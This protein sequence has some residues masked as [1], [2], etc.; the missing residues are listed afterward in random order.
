MTASSG[1]APSGLQGRALAALALVT[2]ISMTG[3]GLIIPVVPFLSL[4]LGASPTEVTGAIGVYSIGQFIASPLWGKMSD[5]WGRR[6]VLLITLS[7]AAAL[8]LALPYAGS[9][10]MLGAIRFAAGLAAGNVATAFAVAA[11][12]STPQNRA[13]A[14]GVIG[15]GLALGFIAGPFFGGLL[16]GDDP[17]SEDFVRACFT[18]AA[19]AAASA[20]AVALFLPETRPVDLGAEG[21]GG[22]FK[23]V[24]GQPQV[25]PLLAVTLAFFTAF[26]AMEAIVALWAESEL[27]WGPVEVGQLLG[28]VGLVAAILQA[29][30]AGGLAERFGERPVLV[31]GLLIFAAGL[32]LLAT[33]QF[34]ALAWVGG[35]VLAAGFG[36]ISPTLQSLISKAAA[37]A[38]RGALIGLNQAAASLARIAGPLSAGPLFEHVDVDAPYAFGAALTLIALGFSLA[39]ARAAAAVRPA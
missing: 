31:A 7:L 28:G 6:P 22:A 24:L 37:D 19:V 14:M 12:V 8:Y 33:A 9:V 36:L 13:R 15:A 11:D 32:G 4:E 34:P 35:G 2:F 17:S 27:E 39:A 3:F 30:V 25:L 1:L 23:R 26:S 29:T 16:V 20:V 38:D 5:R 18:A 21:R 10:L